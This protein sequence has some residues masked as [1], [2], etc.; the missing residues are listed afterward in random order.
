MTAPVQLG[1]ACE[2]GIGGYTYS[3]FIVEDA[4]RQSIAKVEDVMDE[5]D[6]TLAKIISNPGVR[7]TVNVMGKSGSTLEAV[8]IGDVV[9]MNSIAMMVED[10]TQRRSRG[11]LKGTLKLI[12]EDSMTYS[13]I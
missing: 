13:G 1:T 9:T 3:G 6:A 5:D 4:E 10:A 11:V 7:V 2:I 8:K 12:K